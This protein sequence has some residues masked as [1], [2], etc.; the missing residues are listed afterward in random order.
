MPLVNTSGKVK[1][2]P[3]RHTYSLTANSLRPGI[4]T[5]E[6]K[7]FLDNG[8][9]TK[10]PAVVSRPNDLAYYPEG[11]CK[12]FPVATTKFGPFFSSPCVRTLTFK[13]LA[14]RFCPDLKATER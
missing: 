7:I 1:K 8:L 9:L 14:Y 2:F 10:V 4:A 3:K 12:D 5:K 11:S 6:S 13:I